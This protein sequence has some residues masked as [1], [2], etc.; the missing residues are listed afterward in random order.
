MDNDNNKLLQYQCKEMFPY[1]KNDLSNDKIKYIKQLLSN[2]KDIDKKSFFCS[3]NKIILD[4]ETNGCITPNQSNQNQSNQIQSKKK[5][6][7]V[8]YNKIVQISYLLLDKNNN[9][10]II[11]I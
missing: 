9:I 2:N 6:K 7:Y 10:I 3:E 11:S 1:Y 5:S 4:V 8:V